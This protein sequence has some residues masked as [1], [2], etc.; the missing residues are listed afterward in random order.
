MSTTSRQWEKYASFFYQIEEQ[1]RELFSTCVWSMQVCKYVYMY[2]SFS[3]LPFLSSIFRRFI[4]SFYDIYDRFF[5]I[6]SQYLGLKFGLKHWLSL[7]PRQ[8]TLTQKILPEY[9]IIY[10][11]IYLYISLSLSISPLLRRFLKSSY[12][13]FFVSKNDILKTVS[14]VKYS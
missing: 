3:L 10:I 8:E 2:L 4:Y 9:N 13:P 14:N 12:F 1:E 5:Y 6:C 7:S 11:H